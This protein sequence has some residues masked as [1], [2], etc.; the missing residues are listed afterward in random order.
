MRDLVNGRRWLA[1]RF[2]GN[3][4]IVRSFRIALV[5]VYVLAIVHLLGYCNSPMS[6]LGFSILSFVSKIRSS[7][8]GILY[9]AVAHD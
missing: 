5:C 2:E 6:A 1:C 7:S 9:C 4:H 3:G 8:S